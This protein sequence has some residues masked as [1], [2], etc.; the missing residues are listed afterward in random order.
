MAPRKNRSSPASLAKITR[1]RFTDVFLRKRLFRLLDDRRRPVIWISA[2]PGAGKTTLVSS[3]LAERDIP[4]LW[5]RLDPGDGDAATFFHY[6]GLAAS[7]AVPRRLERLPHLTAEY[8]AG[9]PVFARRYFEAL[10]SQ[11]EPPFALV[12]DNYQ[13]VSAGAAL[14]AALR[15]GIGALPQGF[16]TI[17][18][19]RTSPPPELARLLVNDPLALIGWEDV[20]LT[21][22][23]VKGIER[24]RR[25]KRAAVESHQELY[26]KTRGWAAGLVLLLEQDKADRPAETLPG[27]SPQVLFDYFAGEIFARVDA[28]TQS[29]LLASALVPTM[30][31]QIVAQLT[32][33]P[34]AGE[35]LGKMHRNNYFT[36]RHSQAE[37][38]Y[39]YHPLF[40][41]F[42]LSRARLALAPGR[43][44]ALQRKAAALLEADGQIENA[45]AL[46]Q[47]A[48]D[49]QGLARLTARHARSFI[50]HGRSQVVEGWL[51]DLPAEVRTTDAWLAYWHG[52][53]RLAFSPPEARTHFEQA[54]ARWTAG[55]DLTGRCLAWCALVDSFVFEWGNFKPLEHWIAEME[56]LLRGEAAFADR[57]VEAQVAC[58]MFLALMYVQPQH[59]DM[60]R[61]EQRVRQIILHGD[62]S[63]LQAKIGNHLLIYYTWWIGDLAKAE[64]LV[65]SLRKK[66]QRSGVAPLVEITWYT[67][68]AA[69]Y[70]MSAANAECIACVDRGLETGAASGVHTWDMLLCS[71]G[72]FGSLSSGE[73]EPAARYLGR[74]E[75]LLNTSRPMDTAM[76]YYLSAWYRLAQNDPAAAREFARTAVN[77]AEAAGARFPAAVMRNDL[78]RVLFHLGDADAARTEV[79]RA[80]A[81]GRAMN[82]QTIEYLTFIVEAEAA[83]ESGDDR[84]CLESLRRALSVGKAQQFQNHTWWSSSSMA[85]LYAKALAGGIEEPYVAGVIRQRRLAPPDGAQAPDNWPWPLRIHTLGR[86]AVLKNGEPMSFTGKAPRKPLEL[87]KALIALGGSD[88]N[89]GALTD[90]LWPDLE[91]DKAQRAFET[92]LHR[93]RK[94]LADEALIVLK[95]GR[96]TLEARYVWVDSWALERALQVL[97]RDLSTPGCP[98]AALDGLEQHLQALYAGH[99][100]AAES[101]S[102]ALAQ[103]ERLRSRFLQGLEQL[104]RRHEARSDWTRAVRCY[105]RGLEVEPLAEGLYYRLMCCYRSLGQPAEALAV[106]HRCRQTLRSIL[107][108]APSRDIEALRAALAA[109]AAPPNR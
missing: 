40:R 75:G 56:E 67:M 24:L 53:C 85:R 109:S 64:L 6:L 47:A 93:L 108:I 61:W 34:E 58:G 3:Y 92:A 52:I 31:A 44:N 11:I 1:P 86:F 63:Q 101:G 39:E 94:L 81:E 74:M 87:L 48:G 95:D 79:A 59:P 4:H 82:A 84:A 33:S 16:T 37:A 23:E 66:I 5:Y 69:Y 90:A 107:G 83:M 72:V 76:Y 26:R 14:H 98:A 78:G 73:T 102:W 15:E 27:V 7:N 46:L 60:P 68:A 91:G 104:G 20:Q 50:A 88:V 62:D 8:L 42:L 45:A 65:S 12:F 96:L 2:P 49:W 32:G 41:E 30:T 97:E 21:L 71:Q 13:D 17:V 25:R 105:R 10:A 89:Q 9:V 106:Y 55:G 70:W 43:L 57:E 38:A 18:Q 22:E 29:V 99:F 36:L 54:Y 77:M 100:L 51:S 80:R 19:S 35:L 28:E 103:R